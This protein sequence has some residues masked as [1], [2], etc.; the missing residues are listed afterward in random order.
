MGDSS[1]GDSN[2]EDSNMGI[3]ISKFFLPPQAAA[4]A[5][6]NAAGFFSNFF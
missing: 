1:M 4:T 5:V 6:S 2:M 3:L